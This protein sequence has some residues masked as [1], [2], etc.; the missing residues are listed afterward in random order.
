[1]SESFVLVQ[2]NSFV[3]RREGGI[4]G[5]INREGKV[6]KAGGKKRIGQF[7]GTGSK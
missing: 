2:S 7:K 4:I 1:M 3:G 5:G 6:G